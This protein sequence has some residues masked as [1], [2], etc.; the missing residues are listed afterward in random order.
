M[1]GSGNRNIAEM[2]G[3]LSRI[4]DLKEIG[5]ITLILFP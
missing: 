1:P 4:L 2:I 3:L 5:L